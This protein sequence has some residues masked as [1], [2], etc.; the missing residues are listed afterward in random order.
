MRRHQRLTRV[1]AFGLL[2]LAVE[3]AGRSLTFRI[4]VG[5]HVARPAYAG[6]DYYPFLLIAV[7]AGIALLLA[8]LC[9]RFALAHSTAGAARRL[10]MA[11]GSRSKHEAPRVRIEL[12]PR[13]WLGSFAVTAG[14][15]LVQNDAERFA[16][17]G[18]ASPFG[19]WLHSSALPVFA[20]LSVLTAV[21][22]RGVARWLADYESYARESVAH[23]WALAAGA[24]TL[25][26]RRPRAGEV[27]PR[28]LHGVCF[29]SRPPPV[30][31]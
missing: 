27:A 19:P 16:G 6:A 23:A 7:K 9:W 31:A 3:L 22:W 4:D 18:L 8:R 21:V 20:V 17:S 24:P 13:L 12:S 15:F 29:E 25:V 28:R 26:P 11:L 30:P 10:A 1:L 5:R 14:I 2:A